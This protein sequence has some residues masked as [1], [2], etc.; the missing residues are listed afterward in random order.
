MASYTQWSQLTAHIALLIFA[1][2]VLIPLCINFHQF[3]N[4]C[5][6]FT[7]GEYLQDNGDFDP[8]WSSAGYCLYSIILS[9]VI[10]LIALVQIVRISINITNNEEG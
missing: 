10:I 1:S 7:G 3:G 6:L 9:A 5:L 8:Q 2:C 4:H